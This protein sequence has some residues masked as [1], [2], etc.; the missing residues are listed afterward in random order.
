M[1]A[2]RTAGRRLIHTR[3]IKVDG[4]RR[5][6][7]HWDLEGVLTD[8]RPNDHELMTGT[9]PGGSPIHEMRICL[10]VNDDLRIL[11]ILVETVSSPFPGTCERITPVYQQ[12]VGLRIEAGFRREITRIVGGTRGCTHVSD[13]LATMAT[14]AIQTICPELRKG[15]EIAPI[16]LD[17]CHTF[18]ARGEVVATY[19]PAGI[20]KD[21]P[22]E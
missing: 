15:P 6:D 19:F 7:G 20:R 16:A 4:H 11:G 12:F 2:P 17:G 5:T 3:Q 1:A 21:Q 14:T 9:R 10:T 18:D 22:E 8:V 13:L